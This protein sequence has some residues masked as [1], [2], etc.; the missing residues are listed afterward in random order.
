MK[1]RYPLHRNPRIVVASAAVIALA[2]AGCGSSSKKSSGGSA[3]GGGASSTQAAST[4]SGH[5]FTVGLAS[6]GLNAPFP[7]AI[8]K[9][10][11]KVAAQDGIKAL[12]L[13]GKLSETTQES[14]VR[15]LIA[16]HVN[17]IIIDVIDPGPTIAMVKAAGAAHIPVMLVHGYAGTKASPAYPGVTYEVDENET[18]AGTQAGKLALRAVPKGGQTAIITGTPGYTA[19]TQRE[20]GFLSVVKPTHK[21]NVVATQSG[22]WIATGG[23]SACSSILEAHPSIALFYTEADDMAIGCAKAE[24]AHNSKAKIVSIGG[25]QEVKGLI[26]SGTVAGTVCYEPETE[27]EIVMRAMDAE[28][29][30]KKKYSGQ[31]DFY[32]TPTVTKSNLSD[33]GYQW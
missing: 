21:Y 2:V 15:T 24:K 28:L 9:G 14:D 1:T 18:R 22:N 5:K 26:A 27:G 31:V 16:E 25:E 11:R 3:G 19:V 30:G 10:V 20:D 33:C 13:D 7:V 29:T 17:G 4:S 12:V 8:A 23:Y 32:S 6:E